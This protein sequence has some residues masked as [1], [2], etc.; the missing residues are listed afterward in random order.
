MLEK[1]RLF[2]GHFA[3]QVKVNGKGPYRLIFDTGAPMILLSNRIA[4]ECNLLRAGNKRP[5][6]WNPFGMPGQVRVASLQI[7]DLTAEDLSAVVMDH[8]TVKAIADA[9]GPIDGIVGFPFFARYATAIDYQA[10]TMTFTHNGFRPTDT[11]QA[12]MATLTASGRDR[13]PQPRVM[14]PAG[15]WGMRV[16]KESDDDDSGVTVAEVYQGGAADRAGLRSGD[17]LLTI[18]GRWT[19]TV[20]DTFAATEA[21]K[22]GQTVEVSVRRGGTIVRLN[23]SPA[24]GS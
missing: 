11:I 7:G 22:P 3:V 6:A 18:A 21:V 23:I 2:S 12:L 16:A 5:A 10:R 13:K 24:V 8:P 9:L 20:A 14:A 4:R 1:G 15:Q 17:R 19:D